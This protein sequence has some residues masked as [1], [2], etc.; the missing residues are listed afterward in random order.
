MFSKIITLSLNPAIDVTLW[1]QTLQPDED[2]L[3]EGEQYDAAGKAMNV[4]RVLRYYG[5]DSTALVLAGRHN[6]YRYEQ[7]LK[8]EKVNYKLITIDGYIRENLS[9]VQPDRTVTRLMREGFCVE[10]ETVEEI[11]TQ[12]TEVVEPN[13][14]VVISG[15]LPRGISPTVLKMIC[16]HITQLGGKISLDTTSLELE[17]ILEIRP[18]VMKP[19]YQEFCQ[20]AGR[21]LSSIND[22]VALGRQIN[23]KG[24]ENCLV[25]LGPEGILYTSDSGV[26][27]VQVPAVDVISSVGSGDCTLA[28]FI[29]SVQQELP[30]E[31]CLKVAAA[32]GT[33]ACLTEGTNPPPKLATANILQQLKVCKIPT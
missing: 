2:N 11:K 3:V 33:A 28:G 7:R 30:L 6:L 17:D 4:S 16:R 27:R 13:A 31:R 18:W 19:N 1:T 10:Y 15:K 5:L 25:S 21:E 12:L 26:F 23:A 14:L 20:L 24:V 29:M 22:M 9:I 32:F 8:A